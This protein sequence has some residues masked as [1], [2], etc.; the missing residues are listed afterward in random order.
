MKKRRKPVKRRITRNSS[1]LERFFDMYRT[2][3]LPAHLAHAGLHEIF[4]LVFPRVDT[5]PGGTS[6]N[7]GQEL[8]AY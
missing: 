2:V 6:V 3:N 4:R 1:E 8:E 5:N 7:G